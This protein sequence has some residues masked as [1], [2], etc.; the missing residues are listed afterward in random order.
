MDNLFNQNFTNLKKQINK[1]RK[2]ENLKPVN[3]VKEDYPSAISYLAGKDF[4]F[5]LNTFS[6]ANLPIFFDFNPESKIYKC[7][8]LKIIHY[9]YYLLLETITDSPNENTDEQLK[10]EFA[11]FLKLHKEILDGDNFQPLR[12]F[13]KKASYKELVDLIEN[14]SRLETCNDVLKTIFKTSEGVDV[15]KIL[16]CLAYLVRSTKEIYQHFLYIPFIKLTDANENEFKKRKHLSFFTN[17]GDLALDYKMIEDIKSLYELSK[18][19]PEI[20]AMTKSQVTICYPNYSEE[21]FL[22]FKK[23][24]KEFARAKNELYESNNKFLH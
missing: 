9:N 16:E 11:T 12:D 15:Q 6:I 1:I 5:F 23:L 3:I 24:L 10:E 8:F 20:I 4:N 17:Y 14:L 2:S 21:T 13:L 7:S 18:F 19:S 22:A